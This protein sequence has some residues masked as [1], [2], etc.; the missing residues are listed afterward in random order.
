MQQNTTAKNEYLD[1]RTLPDT[2]SEEEYAVLLHQLLEEQKQHQNPLIPASYEATGTC[3][4]EWRTQ[5]KFLYDPKGIPYF[6][7]L[8]AGGVFALGFNH[9]DVIETVK[10]QLDRMPLSPR[11]GVSP[12]QSALARKLNALIP[13]WNLPFIFIGNSGTEAIEAAIKL[14]RLATRRPGLIGTLEGYHGMS[15]GTLSLSGL[16]LWKE[17]IEPGLGAIKLVPHGNF[18]ALEKVVDHNTAA[19]VLEPIPWAS[20][21]IVPPPDYFPKIRELCD[22]KGV[23]LIADEIQT[24]LGRTGKTFALQHWNIKPDILCIGKALTGGVMPVSAVLYND[25]VKQAEIPRPLFNNSSFGGNPLACAAACTT[26]DVMQRDNLF[27]RARELGNQLET[28]FEQLCHTYPEVFKTH[29][30]SGLMRCI[31]TTSPAYGTLLQEKLMKQHRILV[32]AMLHAPHLVRVSPPFI[33]TSADIDQL[34]EACLSCGKELRTIG[35]SKA[36]QQVNEMCRKVID[37]LQNTS[38]RV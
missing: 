9:P 28:G 23:L 20:G 19:I 38:K 11:L 31:E 37:A 17:G 34:I 14:A 7:C 12:G 10:K 15:T 30:G 33:A 25:K 36:Q 24:G 35:A 21:C 32:A 5:G 27:E 13:E 18:K 29:H 26:L 2:L 4:I 16:K 3:L 6:D 1:W 22:R 8:G